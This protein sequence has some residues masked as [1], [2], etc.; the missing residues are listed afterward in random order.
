MKRAQVLI[1]N[2]RE[3]S[4]RQASR[5]LPPGMTR[6]RSREVAVLQGLQGGRWRGQERALRKTI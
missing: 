5:H 4:T 6:A 2:Q 1:I 3:T